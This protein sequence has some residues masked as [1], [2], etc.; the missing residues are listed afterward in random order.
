ML[1]LIIPL[2]LF[3][4][5]S[6]A[7]KTFLCARNQKNKV[8]YPPESCHSY[9]DC[10]VLT[11]RS[12]PNNTVFVIERQT[13]VPHYRTNRC[14]YV[15]RQRR[16]YNGYAGGYY[17]APNYGGGYAGY[18]NNGY[19]AYPNAGYANGGY[20]GYPNGGYAG[21]G[22][23]NNGGYAGYPN[24]GYAGYAGYSNGGYAGY[25]N[26]GYAPGFRAAPNGGAVGGGAGVGGG[27]D[28]NSHL[29]ANGANCRTFVSC[30]T[31]GRATVMNCGPGT[32]FNPALHVCDHPENVGCY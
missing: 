7:T 13:C 22:G 2:L 11:V 8:Q 1:R 29:S 20:A 17:A 14:K 27:C 19:G 3:I 21:Y 18:P 26:G 31:A 16:Y 28:A 10:S 24:G 6:Y 9:V 23:Y 4:N 12:C 32:V 25:P 5:I 15:E 30:D